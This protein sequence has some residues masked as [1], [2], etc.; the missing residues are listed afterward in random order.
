MVQPG[1]EQTEG[2]GQAAGSQ[3][4]EGDVFALGD[5]MEHRQ[6]EDRR[7][8]HREYEDDQSARAAVVEVKAEIPFLQ[9]AVVRFQDIAEETGLL[10]GVIH[11]SFCG[12]S[13]EG[14]R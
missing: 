4:Q 14:P 7:R 12:Q 6:E 5:E 11:S 3:Q 1:A 13:A 8:R 9:E 2:E 10:C